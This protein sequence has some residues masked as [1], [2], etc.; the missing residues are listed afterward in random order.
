MAE[1]AISRPFSATNS[2]VRLGEPLAAIGPLS[3]PFAVKRAKY[4]KRARDTGSPG[5]VYVTWLASDPAEGYPGT[6]P[7]GGPLTDVVCTRIAP[8]RAVV[9]DELGRMIQA[10]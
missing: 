2:G 5:V 1:E 8:R 4:L 6:P 9:L 3:T 10:E 7:G